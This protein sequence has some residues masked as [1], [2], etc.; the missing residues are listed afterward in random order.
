MLFC[1]PCTPSQKHSEAPLWP[2]TN[3]VVLNTSI[4]VNRG[5]FEQVVMTGTSLSCQ[6]SCF[7]C[8]LSLF[9]TLLGFLWA[10]KRDTPRRQYFIGKWLEINALLSARRLAAVLKHIRVLPPFSVHGIITKRYGQVC[11]YIFIQIGFSMYAHHITFHP[12]AVQRNTFICLRALVQRIVR[13]FNRGYSN[14]RHWF[15]TFIKGL[16]SSLLFCFV[17]LPLGIL[18]INVK[19]IKFF[20]VLSLYYVFLP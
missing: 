6:M 17:F 13:V 20:F 10:E 14:L 18:L 8:F 9:L 5:K 2:T 15:M 1:S 16:D 4:N 3:T 12:A 7:V 19:Q 11:S